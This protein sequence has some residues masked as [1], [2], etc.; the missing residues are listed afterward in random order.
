MAT[1]WE[2]GYWRGS[3][4][5]N[6]SFPNANGDVARRSLSPVGGAH[7]FVNTSLPTASTNTDRVVWVSNL[8]V[9]G[10]SDGTDWR[11]ADD[12]TVIPLV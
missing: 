10:Y 9:V 8:E 1:P 12:N 11:Q 4:K 3:A 5:S 2:N 6:A 7:T